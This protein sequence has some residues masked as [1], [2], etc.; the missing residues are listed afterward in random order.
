MTRFI[1]IS[2]SLRNISV[3]V[4]SSAFYAY[5]W[6]IV[7]PREFKKN[8]NIPKIDRK[9]MFH[10]GIVWVRFWLSTDILQPPSTSL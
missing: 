4:P 5:S 2:A 9:Q 1:K 6:N 8:N 7:R 3:G 10:K